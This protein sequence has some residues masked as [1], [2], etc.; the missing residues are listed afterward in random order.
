MKYFIGLFS[1][2]D[3]L[4]GKIFS[5]LPMCVESIFSTV[6]LMFV[7]IIFLPDRWRFVK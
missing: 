6:L 7:I 1:G 2:F 5:A 3:E 4:G